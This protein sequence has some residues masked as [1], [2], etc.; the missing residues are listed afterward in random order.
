M[1]HV[2]SL[3]AACKNCSLWH[4]GTSSLTRDHTQAPCIGSRVSASRH[5]RSP[6]PIPSRCQIIHKRKSRIIIT[7]VPVPPL[8]DLDTVEKR[9]VLFFTLRGF[10]CYTPMADQYSMLDGCEELPFVK[11][12]PGKERLSPNSCVSLQ[13]PS[14]SWRTKETIHVVPID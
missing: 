3:V 10:S 14:R 11:C 1:G 12:N 4:V 9:R 6:W 8:H 13:Y 7:A 2:G 5:Q